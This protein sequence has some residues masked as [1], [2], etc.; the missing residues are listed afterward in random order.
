M[1]SEKSITECGGIIHAPAQPPINY[2][3]CR[4]VAFKDDAIKL[5]EEEDRGAARAE[6]SRR[7]NVYPVTLL[8]FQRSLPLPLPIYV[9]SHIIRINGHD[10]DMALVRL[11]R[12]RD[13]HSNSY[14]NL[15]C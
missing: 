10:M 3:F 8:S 6:P 4:F 11:R 14:E 1:A 9:Q 5:S 7:S 15:I 13:Q 12:L 2:V